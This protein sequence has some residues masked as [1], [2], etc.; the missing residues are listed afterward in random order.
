MIKPVEFQIAGLK[1]A[2]W[3]SGPQQGPLF[4]CCH[5]WL[6]NA[7][8]FLPLAQQLPQLNLLSLDW[9][10]HGLSS[11]VGPEGNYHFIDWVDVLYQLAR[12][13]K[14]PLYLIG[15]SMGALASSV[16]AASF[17]DRVKGLVLIEGFGPMSSTPEQAIELV[18]KS[19]KSR[20]RYRKKS[21]SKVITLEQAIQARLMASE[22]LPKEMV[23]LLCLRNL[24]A[25]EEGGYQ[26][27]TD[28]RLKSFSPLRMTEPQAQTFMAGIECEVLAIAATKGL[29][30]VQQSLQHRKGL[31]RHL[32]WAELEGGHHVHMS[33]A[34]DVASHIDQWLRKVCSSSKGDELG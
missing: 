16:F 12:Q 25:L 9:P 28:P 10:G 27:R 24:K 32:N 21:N 17:P 13:L 22:E 26:W 29:E 15:H 19:L 1:L 18:Q 14:V 2:G 8:S 20:E 5:G 4:L 34:Q 23:E 3:H 30:F 31:V 7:D 11:H 6:D 33:H